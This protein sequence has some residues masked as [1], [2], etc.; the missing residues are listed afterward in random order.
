[1]LAFV[2]F[3]L[4][5]PFSK[6][7]PHTNQFIDLQ[8]GSVDR[9]LRVLTNIT[10]RTERFYPS[11]HMV[12]IEHKWEVQ[13]TSYMSLLSSEGLKL[14]SRLK[15]SS[16]P[17]YTGMSFFF[18]FFFLNFAWRTILNGWANI[19]LITIVLIII[20]TTIMII[21]RGVNIPGW[22]PAGDSYASWSGWDH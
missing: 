14:R 9:F 13:L 17:A 3:C 7:S 11:G 5:T 8:C 1:M 16:R 15:I 2:I 10:F 20:T 19:W 6:D 12:W 21:P 18:F 4:R 22:H